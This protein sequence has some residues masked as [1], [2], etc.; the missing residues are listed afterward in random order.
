MD[1]PFFHNICYTARKRLFTI[2]SC[3]ISRSTFF[4]FQNHLKIPDI[5][6]TNLNLRYP[7]EVRPTRNIFRSK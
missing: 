6:S 3:R 5:K 2:V 7:T 1:S 4:L